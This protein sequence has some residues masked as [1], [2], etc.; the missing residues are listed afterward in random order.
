MT[1]TAGV[2]V[3]AALDERLDVT[4][5]RPELAPDIE[6][7][8]FA[9]RDGTAEIVAHNPRDRVYYRLSEAEADLLPALDGSRT[10]N[11]LVAGELA[12]TGDLDTGEVTGLVRLLQRGGFL[13]TPYVD[14]PKGVDR[15]LAEAKQSRRAKVVAAV[16]GFDLQWK[17]ADRVLRAAYDK[18]LRHLFTPVGK[19]LTTLV[20]L[21]GFAAFVVTTE[22]QH[23]GFT[24]G[25]VGMIVLLLFVLDLVSITIH[26][27]GHA[28]L[29]LRNGRRV[30]GAGVRLYFGSPA[31]Y[32]ESTDALML[33]QR[34]RL[35]QS[36]AGPWF[37][38]VGAGVAALLLAAFP[39]SG[40]APVA[41]R[42]CA[43]SYLGV[44]LN[45]IPLLELDGYWILSDT[46]RVRDLRPRSLAFVRKD[47]WHK[48]RRRQR[49]TRSEVGLGLYGTAG[50]AFTIL[51][52]LGAV[53]YWRRVGGDLF[54]K[55]I[56]AG[57]LGVLGLV[58]L[59]VVIAGPV[60]SALVA[61]LRGLWGRVRRVV[62][63]VR[64][65]V[66]RRWRV[67]AALLLDEQPIFD[68]VPVS[69]LNELAGVVT[70][71]QV[72][73]GEAV[74]RQGERGDAYYLTRRGTYEVVDDEGDPGT[75]LRTI[76]PGESFGEMALV[77]NAP[78][79]ATVRATSPGQLF[80][81]SRGAFDRLLAERAEVRT[82][83]AT[84][85][86]I[87]EL[88]A[89]PA[90]SHLSPGELADL[91]GQGTWLTPA[92][93]TDV[94][95]EGEEGDAFY[96]V[97]TGQFEVLEAGEYVRTIHPGEHFGE[98]ALLHQVPRV[99]T[100]RAATPARIFR[101]HVAGFDTLVRRAFADGYVRANVELTRA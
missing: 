83:A 99:A 75:V 12:D 82:V 40:F 21:G 23:F 1:G 97:Q 46:L 4:G 3:W 69:V 16:K 73:T 84:L 41:W 31:F 93:G 26:E 62:R 79:N 48:L 36:F 80:V 67:E 64:F 72:S 29:L 47:L 61:A 38:A 92:P 70:L 74:I 76:G 15:A 55:L 56:D 49:L 60:V 78:R 30:N 50:V 45:L 28:M 5:Q 94:V 18:G 65:R 58:V 96:V 57:P 32:I 20:G 33:D 39:E 44:V 90:F 9:L 43:L 8:R 53:S 51:V 91:A 89:L 22:R 17:G 100:V 10:V 27:S 11:E 68:D 81:I 7:G 14:V 34:R 86:Q 59:V 98:I 52:V 71:R 35:W 2:D 19:V 24:T 95:T 87:G 25:S 66:E 13:T 42:F 88:R 77:N 101:L 54:T 37:E 63:A 85:Q 6:V